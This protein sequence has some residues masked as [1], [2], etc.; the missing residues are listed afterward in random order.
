[1]DIS[2]MDYMTK[3]HLPR[4]KHLPKDLPLDASAMGRAYVKLLLL[5]LL[6][7]AP[8]WWVDCIYSVAA[9]LVCPLEQI[10]SSWYL[11]LRMKTRDSTWIPLTFIT[12]WNSWG[13]VPHQM[14]SY[15]ALR[16]SC[17]H[18]AILDYPVCILSDNLINPTCNI[19]SISSVF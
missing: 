4:R 5:Y 6:S 13:D 18:S 10:E 8:C 16:L 7:F 9:A 11:P 19:L 12:R 15:W 2:R 14:S 1:M 17:A 3:S